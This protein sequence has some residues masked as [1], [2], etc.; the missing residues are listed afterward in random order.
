MVYLRAL[1][2]WLVAL[3]AY[4]F[5]GMVRVQYWDLSTLQLQREHAMA[6]WVLAMAAVLGCTILFFIMMSDNKK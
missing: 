6:G 4:C 2:I 3:L 1:F 5:F